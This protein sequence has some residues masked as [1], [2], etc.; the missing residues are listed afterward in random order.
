MSENAYNFSN[1]FSLDAMAETT[2]EVYRKA[3]IHKKAC[4]MDISKVMPLAK[5]ENNKN[6]EVTLDE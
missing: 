6:K 3:I 1:K 5:T 4:L 2:V